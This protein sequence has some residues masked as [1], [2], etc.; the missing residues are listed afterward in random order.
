[1]LVCTWFP[2]TLEK[3]HT[4]YPDHSFSFP[5]SSHIF[6][7]SPPT[8]LYVLHF[9]LENKQADK[10]KSSRMKKGGKKKT[11]N[12]HRQKQT[13]LETIIYRQ[14]AN[15]TKMPKQSIM[16]QNVCFVLAIYWGTSELS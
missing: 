6:P 10:A 5:S 16:R 12:T 11:R 15:K 13:K 1:M 14:K 8:Q 9:F 4:V 3:F 2:N 7:T